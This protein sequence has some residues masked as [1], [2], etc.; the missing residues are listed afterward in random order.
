MS[1]FPPLVNQ[2]TESLLEKKADDIQVLSLAGISTV[3]DYFVLCSANSNTHSKSLADHVVDVVKRNLSERTMGREGFESHNWVVLDY[4]DVVVHIF[5]PDARS[6]YSLERM[7]S[8]A[9]ATVVRDP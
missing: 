2:I 1:A 6:Y 7:W 5:L 4:V 9:P 3:A 8:D